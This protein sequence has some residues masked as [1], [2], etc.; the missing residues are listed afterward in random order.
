MWWFALPVVTAIGFAIAL[1]LFPGPGWEPSG[2]TAARRRAMALFVAAS[3]S[4][5]LLGTWLDER[6][7]GRRKPQSVPDAAA[8]EL[9]E[10]EARRLRDMA[11]NHPERLVYDCGPDD[12]IDA[13]TAEL[14]PD[15]EWAEITKVYLGG[16][17]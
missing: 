3:L 14:D 13:L 17:K 4:P 9:T 8:E 12:E 6:L 10:D 2:I 11:A 5:I 1:F 15:G 7:R 16:D